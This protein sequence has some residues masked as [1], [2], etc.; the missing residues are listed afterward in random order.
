MPVTLAQVSTMSCVVRQHCPP[1]LSP[2]VETLPMPYWQRLWTMSRF[3]ARRAED[4][5]V[6]GRI[7]SLSEELPET[8]E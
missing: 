4:M 8:C 5:R 7:K 1:A 3:C 6:Y 2:H